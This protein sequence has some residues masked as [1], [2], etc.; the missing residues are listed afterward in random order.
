MPR[1]QSFASYIEWEYFGH[2]WEIDTLELSESLPQGVEKAEVWRNEHYELK[3]KLSGTIEGSHIDLHPKVE[4]GSLIPLFE[5]KGSDEY[6]IYDYEIGSCAVGNVLSSEWKD[7]TSDPPIVGYEAELYC[8][9]AR[10][11]VRH[12]ELPKTEWLSEWYLNGPH[13]PEMYPRGSSTELTERYKRERKLPGNEED[14]FEDN[15]QW[16][17]ASFAFVKT[18]G[19]S[20]LVQHTPMDLGPSWSKCLSIEYRPVWGG[21]PEPNVR[22]AIAAITSFLMGRELVNVGHTGF[23]ADGRSISQVALNPRKDNLVSLCQREA[24]LRPVE[25]DTS[26]YLEASNPSLSSWCP[27]ISPYRENSD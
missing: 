10:W 23:A 21:I 19:L 4:A 27:A 13:R 5:I 20:F 18:D 17:G 11:I 7:H 3:A 9:G 24:A 8:S 26:D 14:I 16:G 15:K 6:S 22:E 1:G 12:G 25:T 2:D